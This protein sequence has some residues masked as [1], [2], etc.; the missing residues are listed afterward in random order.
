[1]PNNEIAV[2]AGNNYYAMRRTYRQALP[3]RRTRSG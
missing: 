2:Y 3:A 1:M